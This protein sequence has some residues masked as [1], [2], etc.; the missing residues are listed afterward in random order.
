VIGKR[1]Q[2]FVHVMDISQ[3]QESLR[4]LESPNSA[5]YSLQTAPEVY[6]QTALFKELLDEI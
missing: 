5:R 3:G 4:M 1:I 6:S 2:G